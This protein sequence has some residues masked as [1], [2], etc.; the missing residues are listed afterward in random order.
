MLSVFYIYIYKKYRIDSVCAPL[1]PQVPNCM[2]YVI[3][4]CSWAQFAPDPQQ[5]EGGSG[6]YLT[7]AE[8]KQPEPVPIFL[9]NIG[10]IKLV[11]QASRT[12]IITGWSYN[13]TRAQTWLYRYCIAV[14]SILNNWNGTAELNN[15]KF[16]HA[17]LSF[18]VYMFNCLFVYIL[19]LM[20]QFIWSLI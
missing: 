19:F 1:I 15:L 14:F 17:E 16:S 4:W 2:M 6:T 12:N 7:V 10:W 5:P 18:S 8:T 13:F 9:K 3:R 11:H 20:K